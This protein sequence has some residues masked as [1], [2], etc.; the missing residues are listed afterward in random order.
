MPLSKSRPSPRPTATNSFSDTTDKTGTKL[1]DEN[2]NAPSQ[3]RHERQKSRALLL[4]Q[5]QSG[6]TSTA[7]T[8]TIPAKSPIADRYAQNE[9]DENEAID[10]SGAI[11]ASA[12]TG[13]RFTRPD[14]LLHDL[15]TRAKNRV[16]DRTGRE[17]DKEKEKEKGNGDVSQD[18]DKSFA[19]IIPDETPTHNLHLHH[20]CRSSIHSLISAHSERQWKIRPLP[21]P[22]NHCRVLGRSSLRSCDCRSGP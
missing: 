5:S 2:K 22:A 20:N 6:A 17:R 8:S 3:K 21:R 10:D 7:T 12:S 11:G 4:P 14:Y 13:G 1:T 9:N 16:K 18:F 15:L 19:G